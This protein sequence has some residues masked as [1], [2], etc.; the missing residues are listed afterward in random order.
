MDQLEAWRE[1]TSGAFGRLPSR[2]LHSY[3]PR[4]YAPHHGTSVSP[5]AFTPIEGGWE[6]RAREES[7]KTVD[8]VLQL[9]GTRRARLTVNGKEQTYKDRH[10]DIE[11]GAVA[12]VDQWFDYIAWQDMLGERANRHDPFEGDDLETVFRRAELNIVFYGASSTATQNFATPRLLE[13][14][15]T[16]ALE[17]TNVKVRVLPLHPDGP[18]RLKPHL[19]EPLVFMAMEDSEPVGWT[20]TLFTYPVEPRFWWWAQI[21]GERELPAQSCTMRMSGSQ[22]MSSRAFALSYQ[23]LLDNGVIKDPS[24]LE[25]PDPAAYDPDGQMR[26]DHYVRTWEALAD[27]WVIH[28]LGTDYALLFPREHSHVRVDVDDDGLLVHFTLRSIDRARTANQDEDAYSRRWG[29]WLDEDYVVTDAELLGEAGAAERA[30]ELE[31]Y[32]EAAE[33]EDEGASGD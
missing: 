26:N 2:P 9:E 8:Y 7:G 21:P 31:I 29:A 17:K 19:G 22:I 32:K 14:W 20:A 18:E 10:S 27:Y 30:F 24:E 1:Q 16:E 33:I 5:G 15:F 13:D 12:P 28:I 25:N 11:A 23:D 4:D 6:L 3:L